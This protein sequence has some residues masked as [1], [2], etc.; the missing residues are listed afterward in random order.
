MLKQ[1]GDS[2]RLELQAG[3][4]RLAGNGLN[5]PGSSGSH[6]GV[7]AG[8]TQQHEGGQMMGRNSAGLS[9]PQQGGAHTIGMVAGSTGLHAPARSSGSMNPQQLQSPMGGGGM[10]LGPQGETMYGGHQG[11]VMKVPDPSY[12]NG[13]IGLS[14]MPERGI[15]GGRP[16]GNSV[17]SNGMPVMLRGSRDYPTAAN[18]YMQVC[19]L[20]MSW[21]FISRVL[22]GMEDC[23]TYAGVMLL[24]GGCL[25]CSKL[26]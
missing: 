17:M 2:R 6:F 9:G 20:I 19:T 7:N 21:I 22:N 14:S 24:T 16:D 26:R 8:Y 11:G 15:L 3:S 5:E 1:S 10:R 12:G 13:I 25:A 23:R 4:D 18:G